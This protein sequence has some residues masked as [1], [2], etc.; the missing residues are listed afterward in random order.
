MAGCCGRCNEYSGIRC[1]L[2]FLTDKCWPN[3]PP[4]P[5]P[6][7]RRTPLDEEVSQTMTGI[8]QN[9]RSDNSI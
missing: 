7:L 3:A 9:G 2:S 5:P 4:D 6:A 1:F 8:R